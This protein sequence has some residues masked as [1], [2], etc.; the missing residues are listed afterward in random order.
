LFSPNVNFV[1][2]NKILQVSDSLSMYE[3]KNHLVVCQLDQC[4][5]LKENP[6][7]AG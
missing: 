4:K 3:T 5:N 6:N 2:L 7:Q 1:E